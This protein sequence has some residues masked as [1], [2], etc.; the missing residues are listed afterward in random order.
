MEAY[1]K[2]RVVFLPANTTSI[3]Q[4]MV[5]GVISTVESCY[6]RTTLPKAMAAIDSDSSDGFG[7][8]QLKILWKEFTF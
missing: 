6:L 8:S 7:Q 1:N 4:P 2:I 3:L 5:C